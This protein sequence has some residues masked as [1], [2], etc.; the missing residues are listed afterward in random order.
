MNFYDSIIHTVLYMHL[1]L[2]PY[3]LRVKRHYE[4]SR[5]DQYKIFSLTFEIKKNESLSK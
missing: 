3:F 1:L 5:Q 4:N 2:H